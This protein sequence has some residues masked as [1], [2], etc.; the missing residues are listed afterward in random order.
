MNYEIYLEDTITGK[1]IQLDSTDVD[2]TT[3]FAIAEVKDLLIRRDVITKDLTFKFSDVNNNAFGYA[4]MSNRYIDE[5]DNT[6]TLGGNYNPQRIV[7]CSIYENG[8]LVLKGN[9]RLKSVKQN[10]YECVITGNVKEFTSLIGDSLLTDLDLTS[11]SHEFSVSNIT[12]SWYSNFEWVYPAI[13]YGVPYRNPNALTTTLN[14]FNIRNF[15]PAVFVKSIF[16]RIFSEIGFKYELRGNTQFLDV[17]NKLIVPNNSKV[18]TTSTVYTSGAKALSF[19]KT[20][21][22]TRN[23]AAYP[24][25]VGNAANMAVPIRLDN[26]TDT[27]ELFSAGDSYWFTNNASLKKPMVVFNVDKTFTSAATLSYNMTYKNINSGDRAVTLHMQ[28]MSRDAIA[29]SNADGYNNYDNWD[30][31]TEDVFKLES[32]DGKTRTVT[33]FTVPSTEYQIGKQFMLRAVFR[34][35]NNDTSLSTDN[36]NFTINATTLAFPELVGQS[37]DIDIVTGSTVT[38]KLPTGIKQLDFINSIRSL[39]NLYVYIDADDDKKVIFE[40]YDSYYTSATEA[41]LLNT[42]KDWS[43]YVDYNGEYSDDSNLDIPKNY[44]FIWKQDKDY[45][46]DYYQNRYNK[47]YADLQITDSRGITDKKEITLIFSPT[48]TTGSF[49]TTSNTYFGY[50]IPYIYGVSN[51]EVEPFDS[52]IRLLIWNG[53]KTGKNYTVVEE[54]FDA[55]AAS[56]STVQTNLTALPVASNYLFDAAGTT[57]LFDLH[58]GRPDELFFIK[59]NGVDTVPYSF[60]YY[61]KQINELKS[62]NI[63]YLTCQMYLNASVINQLDLKT[64]ILI[65]KG[66][67]GVSYY[68]VLSVSYTNAESR[69]TVKLQKIL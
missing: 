16:N 59:P 26:L 55:Y 64:P 45:L 47:S 50:P 56:W 9:L 37:I 6:P 49:S 53:A 61:Q 10:T 27:L 23:D 44:N 43:K 34:K 2:F 68:K 41:N 13:Q 65:D 14:P 33:A 40:P 19:V 8:I 57:V 66:S 69:S 21:S 28:L 54:T 25:G 3:T 11:L 38:P 67:N 62:A 46:N 17:F 60:S 15:K 52:N 36:F 24:E 18:N 35:S 63:T 1:A 12:S 30:V 7:P 51:N 20:Q 29:T 42:A 31:V 32:G 48:I 39:F 58:S 4:F 22:D 5:A